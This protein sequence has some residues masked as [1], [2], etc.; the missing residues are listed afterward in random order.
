MRSVTRLAVLMVLVLGVS[1]PAWAARTR[2]HEAAESPV[3]KEKMGGMIGRGVINVAT[4][5]VDLMVHTVNETKAGPPFIGTLT[6]LAS[7][8]GCSVLRFGSGAVDVLMFWVPGFNGFAVSDSYVNC[9][10]EP[11]MAATTSMPAG[12]SSGFHAYEPMS[13]PMPSAAAQPS[14]EPKRTWKK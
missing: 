4:F 1:Q 8:A 10:G 2:F 3:Y 11:A 14:E 12:E 9:V 7:G 5:F 6:G 13:E